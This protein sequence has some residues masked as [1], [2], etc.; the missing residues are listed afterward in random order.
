MRTGKGAARLEVSLVEDPQY[1]GELSSRVF[2]YLTFCIFFKNIASDLT[3]P[4]SLDE[5]LRDEIDLTIRLY[6]EAADR[7]LKHT[8]VPKIKVSSG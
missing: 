1:D 5:E 7:W 4:S 8:R 6:S 3:G 2:S